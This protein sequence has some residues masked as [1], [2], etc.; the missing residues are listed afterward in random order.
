MK[1]LRKLL[2]LC[3]AERRLAAAAWCELH[4]VRRAIARRPLPEV[5]EMCR[6][7]GER[8]RR[9]AL[10]PE[11]VVALIAAAAHA[12]RGR[13]HCLEQSLAGHVLLTSMGSEHELR[14]GVDRREGEFRAHAW[15]EAEGIA[16]DA[17]SSSM[18]TI[19]SATP[20]CGAGRPMNRAAAT[21]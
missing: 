4:R 10:P 9:E 15:I 21:P 12:H 11:R 14:I 8:R 16:P 17:A 3:P 19:W 18:T 20:D 13:C 2:A 7:R 5:A 1:R 6:V